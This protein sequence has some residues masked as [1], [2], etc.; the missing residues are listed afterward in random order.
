MPLQFDS[1]LCDWRTP[2]T[3]ARVLSGM[4]RSY[5]AEAL[6]TAPT[7]NKRHRE[8]WAAVT[9]CEAASARK[10]RMTRDDSLGSDFEVMQRDGSIVRLQFTEAMMPD[11]RRGDEYRERARSAEDNTHDPFGDWYFRRQHIRS[12]L[13]KEIINKAAKN[14]PPNIGLLI[15]LNIGTYGVWRREIEREMIEASELHGSRF[16]SI[17]VL[18][19]GRLYRTWPNPSVG[20]DG[21]M[22]P[23]K[24]VTLGKWRHHY[25]T[26]RALHEMRKSLRTRRRL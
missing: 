20:T 17:W 7:L 14:Y 24:A 25:A 10:V 15:Y 1:F 26:R 5:S 4:R 3:L 22:F 11:R 9:F 23:R 8:I 6:F 2:K 16:R 13:E 19:H 18:W 12:A 21:S